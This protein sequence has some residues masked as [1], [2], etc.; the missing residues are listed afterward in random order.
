MI[1]ASTREFIFMVMCPSGRD[2]LVVDQLGDPADLM[3][4]GETTS[5]R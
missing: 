2:G 5:L 1:P 4:S 3:P